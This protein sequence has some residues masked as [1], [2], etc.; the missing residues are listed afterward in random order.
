MCASYL[1]DGGDR[2]NKEEGQA[3]SDWAGGGVDDELQGKETGGGRRRVGGGGVKKWP[4]IEDR[5][6][7]K[8]HCSMCISEELLKLQA[9]DQ[10]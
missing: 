2:D 7:S 3:T 4:Q 6:S 5:M 9:W 1:F 10:I 8:Q